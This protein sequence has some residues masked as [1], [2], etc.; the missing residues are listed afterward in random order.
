MRV[1]YL[2]YNGKRYEY[3]TIVKLKGANNKEL[4]AV[5]FV[6]D[7]EKDYYMF[8]FK[9]D[10][11]KDGYYYYQYTKEKLKEKLIE[12]TD[13][14]DEKYVKRNPIRMT[15]TTNKPTFKEELE[16]EGLFIA[17][18]WYIFLIAITTIF[19]G[20]IFYWGVISFIFFDYREKKLRKA[21]YKK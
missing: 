5:F 7:P 4:E 1:H 18:V 10:K 6:C 19:K 2:E 8:A 3:G 20:Q 21:G 11:C 15:R 13:E 12:I 14:I 9:D 16:I 17:W